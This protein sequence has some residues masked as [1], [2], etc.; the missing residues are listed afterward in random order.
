[1]ISA[2][3]LLRLLKQVRSTQQS[4]PAASSASSAAAASS[5]EAAAL[6]MSVINP[7]F[8]ID[9]PSSDDVNSSNFD[10]NSNEIDEIRRWR[11]EEDRRKKELGLEGQRKKEQ[12]RLK[13]EEEEW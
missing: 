9:P 11:Q 8:A 12:E 5:S 10:A 1:M 6:P 2:E 7:P 4:P 13:Y 3:Q